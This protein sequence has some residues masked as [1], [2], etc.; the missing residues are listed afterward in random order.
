MDFAQYWR[1][2]VDYK[3]QDRRFDL[4]VDNLVD[5]KDYSMFANQW[6][7]TATNPN[8]ELRVIFDQDSNLV[9]GNLLVEL[10][11]PS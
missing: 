5:F 11:G 10:D 4:I 6:Q 3:F 7:E 2:Q 1:R 8:P 9:T